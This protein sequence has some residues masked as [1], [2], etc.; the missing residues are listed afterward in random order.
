VGR[1]VNKTEKERGVGRSGITGVFEDGIQMGE[2]E[3]S[4]VSASQEL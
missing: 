3:L 2:E 1:R 4:V